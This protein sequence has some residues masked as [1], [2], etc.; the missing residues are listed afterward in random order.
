MNFEVLYPEA[1]EKHTTFCPYRVCPIGAHVDHQFGK[2]AGFAINK[3]ITITYCPT[4]DGS[5]EAVSENMPEKKEFCVQKVK[6]K[7]G[8][9]ADHLRGVIRVLNSEGYSLERGVRCLIKGDLPIGGLSS[10]A[11]VIIAFMLT[12]CK[13]NKIEL[14][15][16]EIIRL[17][18]KVE[19]EYVGV[20]CGTLDQSCEVYSKADHLLFLDT[21]DGT[22]DLLEHDKCMPNYE[23]GIFFSGVPRSL[24]GTKFNMRVDECHAAA[25]Y[26]TAA[27]GKDYGRFFETY[28]RNVS[29]ED[30]Q[31]HKDKLPATWCR[32]AEHFYSEQR[33]V[34][35][36]AQLWQKGD[37][38]SF[39]KTVFESGASSICN[40]ETGSPEL[41]ALYDAMLK[42]DG[43]Y[44]GR[45][46]GA[47]FKGC[48]MAIVDP[49]YKDSITKSITEQYLAQ[50]P[51][52]KDAFSVHYCKTT[53]GVI[54]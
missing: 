30:F 47:G 25:Y 50:F 19:N 26:I 9:W 11:S 17:A 16:N 43:I 20:N 34:E 52:L 33:R 44:G 27:M 3:G 48:C 14:A 32:R 46:S 22:Y 45:F 35:L 12:I 18:Q 4:D 53:D 42:T 39:G 15:P 54:I 40:Y 24:A 28:L 49:S 21:L 38:V 36:G 7:Y 8:D 1:K 31:K 23:I 5:V 41:K 10:S 37:L 13:V 51:N 2:V 6:S 29:F